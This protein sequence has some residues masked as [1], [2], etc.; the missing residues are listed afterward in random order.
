M[1][2]NYYHRTNICPHC[3]RYDEHHIGKSSG[4]W[5]FGFHGEREEDSE[6]NPLGGV[7]SSFSDWKTRLREGKIFDEYEEEISF[8]KFLQLV[9]AKRNEKNN[10]TEY[11]RVNHSS[12][13]I[14]CWLDD[15]GNSFTEGEFS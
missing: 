6:L 11:C 12:H 1:G 5:T 14:D 9:E 13:A 2:T 3:D 10:H 7:V 8:E 4:G 15:D